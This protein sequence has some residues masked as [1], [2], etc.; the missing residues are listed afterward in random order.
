MSLMRILR[1]VSLTEGIS[2]L[3]LLGVAMPLKYVWDL[4]LAVKWVGWAHGGLFIGLGVLALLAMWKSALPIKLAVL[5]G[6]AALLPGGPFFLDRAL[7]RHEKLR[8]PG[9]MLPELA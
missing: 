4:P 2:Y 3:L 5:L 8:E 7:K 1:A 6:I 9:G